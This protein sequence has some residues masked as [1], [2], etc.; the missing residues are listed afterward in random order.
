MKLLKVKPTT[1]STRHQFNIQKNLLSKNNRFIKSTRIGTHSF[2]GRSSITG[3]ITVR[4]KGGA[5]KRLFRILNFSNKIFKGIIITT[6]YD[7]NRNAFL[8]LVFDFKTKTFFNIIAT[9]S[10]FPGA[11][12][13][14]TINKPD[15]K[16]G[17]RTSLKNI[18]TGSIFHSL[19]LKL[20]DSV[21]YARSAGSFC[22]II[23]KGNKTA[24]IKLPSSSIITVSVS[25]FGTIG[26][27]S[28]L[29][30]NKICIGKAGRNRLKGIRPTVRGIAMNPVDHPHGGRANGGCHWVTPWAIPTKGKLTR[31]K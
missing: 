8:S 2:S 22:Q 27:V 31:K 17:F 20:N 16:L 21:K 24:K 9:N 23:Q 6:T 15:L 4:H 10:I 29:N 14:S 3:R 1:N 25:S 19:S 18:P 5:V 7:P 13:S 12:F 11:F 26:V 28:N 30:F